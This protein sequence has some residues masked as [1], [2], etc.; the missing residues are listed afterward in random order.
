MVVDPP[1]CVALYSNWETSDCTEIT[2][3]TFY[4]FLDPGFCFAKS[5]LKSKFRK[6]V[7]LS[8]NTLL[9][10]LEIGAGVGGGGPSSAP[11]G[12]GGDH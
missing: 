1:I 6:F 12:W 9:T 10:T 3:N 11:G 2:G 5:H 8:L 4:I 7:F